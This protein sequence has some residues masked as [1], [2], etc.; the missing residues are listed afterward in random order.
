MFSL[1]LS[2]LQNKEKI[3]SDENDSLVRAEV[4]LAGQQRKIKC[5]IIIAFL[6]PNSL[7]GSIKGFKNG[8]V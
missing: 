8:T 4:K 3:Q 1:N 6:S 2:D 5:L 7:N